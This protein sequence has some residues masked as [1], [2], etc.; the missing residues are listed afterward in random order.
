[1]FDLRVDVY[2]KLLEVEGIKLINIGTGIGTSVKSII[3]FLKQNNINIKINN[4]FRDELETSTAN[5]NLLNELLNKESFLR[6]EDY[7]KKEL[8]F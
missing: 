6:I 5:I 8:S 2:K 7:V 3:D 1:M 4:I